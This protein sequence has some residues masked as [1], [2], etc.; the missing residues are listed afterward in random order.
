MV[1][2][3]I[4]GSDNQNSQEYPSVDGYRGHSYKY[5][6]AWKADGWVRWLEGLRV[7]YEKRMQNMCMIL[8]EWRFIIGHSSPSSFDTDNYGN[9]NDDFDDDV[10]G[11]DG[12]QFLLKTPMY[13]FQFPRDGMFVW[14][15]VCFETHHYGPRKL[16]KSSQKPYL[17]LVAPGVMFDHAGGSW[18]DGKGNGDAYRCFRLCFAPIPQGEMGE[19]SRGCVERCRDSWI[20]ECLGEGDG[21]DEWEEGLCGKILRY[22]QLR[23]LRS[24]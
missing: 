5:S 9:R 15:R 22:D 13:T 17:C 18:A 4:V 16:P 10:V 23:S 11:D 19:A 12:W 1:A 8:E 14:V 2:S 3:I 21:G 20:R 7:G 6:I 24:W